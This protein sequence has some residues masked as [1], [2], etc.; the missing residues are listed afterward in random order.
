MNT[1][2]QFLEGKSQFGG[3]SGFAPV[4]IPSFLFDFQQYAVDWAVRK[5]RCGLFL[6][7]GLGK[8]PIQLVWADNVLRKTNK[9]V[10]VC[11]PLAVSPQTLREGEKFGIQCR[12]ERLGKIKNGDGIVV[13]NY[14]RLHHFS[15][16]DFS[17]VVCDESSIIKM[18]G[19]ETQKIVTE[20]MRTIP[21]RLLCTATAAPNDYIEL[22]TSAEALGELGRM[23]M[24]GR[25]F[26]NDENSLHPIWWGARWVFKAH[27]ELPFWR[28]V[29]SWART[30]RK[31][32]DLGGVR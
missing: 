29:C 21:Y 31:P 25:F 10:L 23:D 26:R 1:Y 15:P 27:A 8:T 14:E 24:V 18:F 30:A 16:S 11:T 32:S 4:T 13:N 19:G 6:D 9:P 2:S 7:C 3:E 5:G 17:G 12:R 28:W 22:G 20:F